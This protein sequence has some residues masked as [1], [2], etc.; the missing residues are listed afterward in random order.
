[1]NR[2]AWNKP[3]AGTDAA[4]ESGATDEE[5]AAAAYKIRTD[6]RAKVKPASD[7]ALE[8]LAPGPFSGPADDIFP[9]VRHNKPFADPPA[10]EIDRGGDTEGL[11][12]G[13][14][15]ECH[16]WMRDVAMPSA[17]RTYDAGTRRDF[18]NSAMELAVTG[19][20]VGEAVAKLRAAGQVTELR[21]RHVIE[22]VERALPPPPPSDENA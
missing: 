12:N 6:R 17:C 5:K 11:L 7:E 10:T 8:P 4:S 14:I 2:A 16:Y 19:A 15:A 22:H 3:D 9:Q 20:R 1:M 18:M 13:L 21:Q